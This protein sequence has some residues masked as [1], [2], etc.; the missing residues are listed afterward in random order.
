MFSIMYASG[1][2]ISCAT[3]AASVPIVVSRSVSRRRLWVAR[4]L[5]N[6]AH[7]TEEERAPA[8][9]VEDRNDI[10]LRPERRPVLAVL[11]ELDAHRHQRIARILDRLEHCTIALRPEGDVR[12]TAE[13]LVGREPGQL[14]ERIVHVDD[15]PHAVRA[16]LPLR[17]DDGVLQTADRSREQAEHAF[18]RHV[19]KR[20]LRGSCELK[21][22][23]G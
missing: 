9:G 14:G 3:P 1:L 11:H 12:Q 17:D 13:R 10:E 19:A 8:R 21:S 5:C 2:F 22:A 4:R 23:Q 16:A 15:A 7:D 6:V 18:T 20:L